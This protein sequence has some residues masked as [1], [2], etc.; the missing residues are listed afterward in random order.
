MLDKLLNKEESICVVGLGYV[1]LPLRDMYLEYLNEERI[2]KAGIFNHQYVKKLL[3]GYFN[4]KGVNH[5]K[6]WLL[7]VLELWRERWMA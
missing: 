1:G 6:L 4:N 2:K 7:F 5:N 3:D